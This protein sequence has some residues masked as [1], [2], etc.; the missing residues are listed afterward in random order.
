MIEHLPTREQE[1]LER[2]FAPPNE[3]IWTSLIDGSAPAVQ[4]DQVRR[5]LAHLGVERINAPLVLPFVRGGQVTGWY[6]TTQRAVGGNEL[7][8]EL[9][10][11]LGPTWLSRFERV[12]NDAADPMASVL[13]GRFGG[14]VYR[15]TGPDAAATRMIANRLSEF[16]ELLGRKPTVTRTPIRPVG[17]IRGDFERALL[18]GDE[19]QAE[20]KI[21]ELKQTGRLNQENIK[22]LE[23][24]LSAGLGLWPQ[25]A[26]D[27]WLIKTLSDLALPPQILADLIEALYRTYV[28]AAEASGEQAALREA[29]AV[30]I[31]TVYPKLFVSRRGI[32]APRVIKAFVLFEQSQTS[33]D[34]AIIASLLTLL[35]TGTDT[36]LFEPTPAAESMPTSAVSLDEA[37]EAFDD[38]QIDRAFEFY[39]RLPLSKKTIS[40]MVSCVGTI[41]TDEAR[42]RLI[43]LLENSDPALV[44]TLAPAVAAKIENL[45][46]AQSSDVA[47]VQTGPE[48]TIMGN[49][50]MRWAE[51]LQ[52]G[53]NL[54]VAERDAQSA[55][56]NWSS[57]EIRDSVSLARQFADIIGGLDGEA[58][59]IA[60]VAVPQIFASFFPDEVR[61]SPAA[62]PIASLLFLLIAMDD[63]LSRTDLD[64]IA[65]LTTLLIEQGLS[66]SEYV[67]LM[68]DLE[69][70]QKRIGSYAY[71]PWSLDVSEALA[72]L[73]SPSDQ[74]RDARLRLFLQVLGQTAGFTHRL[75]PADLVPMEALAKDYGVAPEAV[76]ALKRDQETDFA[77]AVAP[78]SLAGK[79]IGIYTLAEAAGSR[80]KTALEEL[81]PGCK[82]VVNSDMVATA[83]LTSLAKAA[84]VFVFAWKSS[85]HQAFYCVKDALDGREPIWAPGKGTASILRAVLDHLN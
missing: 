16:A 78:P 46:R 21:A 39:T 83:Q 19:A 70:V 34:P 37:D 40:R 84:D 31:G 59:L 51:Q 29:F 50:W 44:E 17:A 62:K 72:I 5:W 8:D 32:R 12:P 25:I 76:S 49:P 69:D 48:T 60:R 61:A 47:P 3:L 7:G 63:T 9:N 52:A 75:V 80:A 27:Q 22:Y 77:A 1:W 26:R 43:T 57:L 65:Q 53:Q 6:A 67:S 35:P 23:V 64:L 41:G 74:A 73:P 56:T 18:A 28:D 4:E 42:D 24:R 45:R 33:P 82:V 30:H 68:G 14:I 85:S 71:L 58:G 13:R 36:S 11:W 66:S 10:A 38:G 81:F 20:A 15:F 55:P 2:F 79:T 54:A